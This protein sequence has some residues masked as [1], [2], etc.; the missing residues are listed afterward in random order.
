MSYPQ[1]RYLGEK[2]EVSSRFRPAGAPADLVMGP[3]TDDPAQRR[4][5]V[6]HLGTGATTGGA[7]GLY[8]W[9][10]GPRP[11]GAG[12]HFHRTMTESFYVL[13]GTVR[14]FNGDRW[15]DGNPGDFLFVP[16]GG[17]HGFRNESGAPATMLILFTPGAPREGY[18]EELA[19]IATTGR[20]PTEEEWTELFLRHD[21]FM[22]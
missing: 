3:E 4:T 17:I 19:E 14:L 6:H 10:M 9:E 2:G 15:I 11:G 8:R 20:Q 5:H 21:Q 7:F 18:F 16:E 12:A 22:V 1:P 13:D